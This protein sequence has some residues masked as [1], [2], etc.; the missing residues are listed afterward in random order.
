MTVTPDRQSASPAG[1]L[2][3][4]PYRPRHLRFVR[5]QDLGDWRIK[6]Y[7]IATF[8]RTARGELVEPAV[9]LA[10]KA[11]PQPAMSD[12]R[13][14][15]GFVIAHDAASVCFALIYWWQSANELHQRVFA[16]PLADPGNFRPLENAGAGCVWELGIIDF[17]RRAWL[18][19]VL[20]NPAGPDIERYLGR[21]LDADV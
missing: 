16:S 15:I 12:D 10:A 8:G 4:R 13:P 18:E 19:D 7:A 11:L 14:G 9:S 5:R 3:Q 1:A 6:V 17:E 20:A 21:K 2:D